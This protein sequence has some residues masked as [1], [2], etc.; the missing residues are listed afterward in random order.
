MALKNFTD[1]NIMKRISEGDRNV[2]KYI[3]SKCYP[4]VKKFILNN[5]GNEEMSKD[6]FQE[7]MVIL[8]RKSKDTEFVLTS[9]V[10]TFLYSV[11]RQLWLKQLASNKKLINNAIEEDMNDSDENN[12]VEQ[13]IEDD[14]K[15]KLVNHCLS[16]LGDPCRALLNAYYYR[17]LSMNEIAAEMGYTNADNAKN[18]K[19]KCFKRLKKLV[20]V[21]QKTIE[22]D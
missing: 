14:R 3:Y 8:F 12:P 7:A 2:I 16:M 18:Q 17:N 11:S 4:M 5:S 19:Y 15:L 9:R 6:I 20:M 22:Y 13:L 21:N 10:S 1:Q